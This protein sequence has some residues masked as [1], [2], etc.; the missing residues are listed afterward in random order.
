MVLLR[1]AVEEGDFR[2][3]FLPLRLQAGNLFCASAFVSS[4]LFVSSYNTFANLRLP[5]CEF[6]HGRDG[7]G[8]KPRLF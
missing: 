6:I 4:Q 7:E 1:C 5:V 8:I 2:R 3:E